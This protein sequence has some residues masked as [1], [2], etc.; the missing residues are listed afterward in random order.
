MKPFLKRFI[1][2]HIEFLPHEI[3]HNFNILGFQHAIVMKLMPAKSWNFFN[4]IY[5]IQ[6]LGAKNI[7]IIAICKRWVLG[8]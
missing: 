1:H 5:I 7:K 3:V 8:A 6:F 2:T 4:V